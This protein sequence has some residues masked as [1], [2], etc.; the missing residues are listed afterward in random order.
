ACGNT[1]LEIGT[2]RLLGIFMSSFRFTPPPPSSD[3]LPNARH[4]L[5]APIHAAA[6]PSSISRQ[7]PKPAARRNTNRHRKRRAR[8]A[9]TRALRH[10]RRRSRRTVSRSSTETRRRGRLGLSTSALPICSIDMA[11]RCRFLP[12]ILVLDQLVEHT[13]KD[14]VSAAAFREQE[15][16]DAAEDRHLTL[17]HAGENQI[18]SLAVV[19]P[20]PY[21]SR[22]RSHCSTCH[23]G[24][25]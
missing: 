13:R 2:G 14:V 25:S 21:V 10:R 18:A 12:P 6:V 4:R 24:S 22:P 17:L 1:A 23:P 20:P 11:N 7:H 3:A 9:R 5:S 8:S 16:A 15:S 19:S